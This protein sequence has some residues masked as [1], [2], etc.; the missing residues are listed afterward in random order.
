MNL[1]Q[2]VQAAN[3][4]S[5][6]QIPYD[7]VAGFV[8]DAIAA[9]NVEVKANFPFLVND[10]DEPIFNET[11]QRLLIIPFAKGRIKEKDSSEFEWEEGYEQFFANI[12]NFKVQY[13]VPDEY[14]AD[15][16][17]DVSKRSIVTYEPYGWGG[18]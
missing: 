15:L 6:D 14:K 3:D 17:A 11:W 16:D 1:K 4:L 2:L 5:D 9:I 12:E 10:I 7:Q 8:N 18:W 13:E